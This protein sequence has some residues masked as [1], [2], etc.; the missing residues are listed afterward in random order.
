M[1]AISSLRE[2]RSPFSPSINV[3]TPEPAV[4]APRDMSFGAV[5]KR[6]PGIAEA[7]AVCWTGSTAIGWG[8]PLSDVDLYVFSDKELEL[9]VDETMETWTAADEKSGL[10][11]LSWMGRYGDTC[12]DLKVWPTNALATV[13]APYLPPHEPEFCGLSYEMQD[14]VYRCS[15]AVPFKND[16]YIDQMRNLIDSSSYRQSLARSI[17]SKVENRLTD[18][19]GQLA[20]GD[21]MTARFSATLAA[22]AAADQ[23]L[24]LAGDVCPVQKWLM[25]RLDATPACGISADEYRTE[26]LDGARPGES[27]VDCAVRIARWAQ[28]HVI[29]VESQALTFR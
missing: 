18:I 23:A 26:V 7:E 28:S 14:L 22:Y 1:N 4:P 8:N 17:K 21:V 2:P 16:A 11:W 27:D 15:I 3:L 9:P 5:L 12:V 20:A 6:F 25:R 19:S 13:L 10:T 29:R 24:V